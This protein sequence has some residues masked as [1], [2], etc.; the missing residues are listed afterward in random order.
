MVWW[1]R[2]WTEWSILQCDTK[3]YRIQ[4]MGTKSQ[5]WWEREREMNTFFRFVRLFYLFL[6]GDWN[7]PSLPIWLW[8]YKKCSCLLPQTN[9]IEWWERTTTVLV[10]PSYATKNW[11]WL[12]L[13]PSL[14]Q[15]VSQFGS[16][17][18]LPNSCV[19]FQKTFYNPHPHNSLC[20]C[21][22][23]RYQYY[24]LSVMIPMIRWFSFWQMHP[25]EIFEGYIYTYINYTY[26]VWIAFYFSELW[27]AMI[28]ITNNT[29]F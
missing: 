9:R 25:I 21:L 13:S 8:Y 7:I 2:L 27:I 17:A 16:Y 18:I 19:K 11:N 3:L 23:L 14:K 22:T 5:D 29:I 20:F 10:Q 24:K 4:P 6:V 28:T 26:I 12:P 15:W 1:F